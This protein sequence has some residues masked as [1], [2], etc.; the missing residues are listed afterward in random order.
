MS[1][2]SNLSE[3]GGAADSL[4]ENNSSCTSSNRSLRIAENAKKK[5]EAEAPLSVALKYFSQG[6]VI[7]QTW[8]HLS[9]IFWEQRCYGDSE[10]IY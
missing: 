9:V 4:D 3:S 8:P 1:K 10:F 2:E 6:N 7:L 5:S